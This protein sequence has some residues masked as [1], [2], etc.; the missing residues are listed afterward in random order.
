MS[1]VIAMRADGIA[2]LATD[3][4]TM[5]QTGQHL[6][7]A[8]QK[9]FEI[10]PGTFYAWSGYT[11]FAA[12]QVQIAAAFGKTADMQNLRAFA[13]QLDA[14]SLPLM[15]QLLI[16]LTQIQ[17]LQ[18]EKYGPELA[19][20]EPFHA[21][22]LC[23]ISDGCPGFLTREFRLG[24]GKITINE[25]CYFAMPPD[26][27]RL[28][29]SGV[30]A[31]I[32]HVLNSPQ[33]WTKGFIGVAETLVEHMRDV[34][35]LIGGPTQMIVI[36]QS[37]A[38]WV[39]RPPASGGTIPSGQL[40]TATLTS[41]V[42]YSGQIN[43]G[44]VNAGTFNGFSF[45]G[46]SFTAV[47]SYGNT[48]SVNTSNHFYLQNAS[49]TAVASLQITGGGNYGV[50][51]LFAYSVPTGSPANLKIVP[52]TATVAGSGGSATLPSNPTGFLLVVINGTNRWIPFY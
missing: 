1:T 7:D 26:S 30:R 34:Q 46:C 43:A 50:L 6:S 18:P 45:V 42:I 14:A 35:P 21:Y 48:V 52:A 51:N 15:E 47:D 38:R 29:A 31:D 5:D 8:Q 17:H 4:R 32:G 44:Q 9:I 16:A 23:G 19:G 27:F 12:L 33:T 2:V 22:T 28:Y 25:Q 20:K 41:G 36:D 13:D 40:S 24:D 39:H 3:S 49:G 37:G 11:P 10:A